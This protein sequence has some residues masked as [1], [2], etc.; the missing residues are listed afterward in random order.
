MCD[1][2]LKRR[3]DKRQT[4]TSR[5]FVSAKHNLQLLFLFFNLLK[6]SSLARVAPKTFQTV[7]MHFFKLFL[8][9]VLASMAVAAPA[10]EK[11]KPQRN[12]I[13]GIPTRSIKCGARHPREQVFTTSQ[14]KTAA[15]TALDLVD[16]G[17]QLGAL[18]IVQF[19]R[20]LLIYLRGAK[21]PSPI[22]I[23][24]CRGPPEV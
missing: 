2:R 8:P 18:C 19:Y 9:V 13:T 20:C 17:K 6:E 22:R 4:S 5:V 15:E 12:Q 3:R 1:E 14:I 21:L 7:N 11:P 16:A 10:K 23:P 24:R